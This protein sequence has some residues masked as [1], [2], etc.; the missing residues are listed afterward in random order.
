MVHPENIELRDFAADVSN[1]DT[2]SPSRERQSENM[3]EKLVTLGVLRTAGN[4]IVLSDWQPL[5]M[6]PISTTLLALNDERFRVSRRKHPSN[7][8][9]MYP[10]FDVSKEER[11]RLMREEQPENISD[12][13]L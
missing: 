5:N 2:S 12:M 8:P 7:I 9:D 10:T 4:E 13:P 11:S 6:E 1:P 3:P